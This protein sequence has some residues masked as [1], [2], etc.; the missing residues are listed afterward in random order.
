MLSKIRLT[1]LVL[2]AVSIGLPAAALADKKIWISTPEHHIARI[3]VIGCPSEGDAGSSPAPPNSEKIIEIDQKLEHRFSFYKAA[4]SPMVLAPQGWNCLGMYG[5]NGST[6]YIAP[7]PFSKEDLYAQ[8]GGFRGPAIE[9]SEIDGDTPGRFEVARVVA[10]VF[11][12]HKTFAQKIINEGVEPVGNFPFGPYPADQVTRKGDDLVEFQTPPDTEGL[13]TMG[14]LRTNKEP[15]DGTII[16]AG[17]LSDK[18]FR[19]TVRL[20]SKDKDLTPVIIKQFEKDYGGDA[21]GN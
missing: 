5:A 9:V 6:L 16:L 14:K 12:A 15:I 13:G 2:I 7:D 4:T 21:S 1:G 3:P 19:A 20:E 17:L 11:P 18:M 8:N 10:R